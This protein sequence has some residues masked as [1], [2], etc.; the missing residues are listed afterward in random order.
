MNEN[1]K[2]THKIIQSKEDDS[3]RSAHFPNTCWVLYC[4]TDV[5]LMGQH[6]LEKCPYPFGFCQQAK[7]MHI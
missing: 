7:R 4:A 1:L 2:K 6:F 3:A 5:R